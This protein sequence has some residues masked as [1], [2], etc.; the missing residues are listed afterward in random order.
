[1]Y[2]LNINNI[3]IIQIS[4]FIIDWSKNEQDKKYKLSNLRLQKLLYF[5]QGYHFLHY[6]SELFFEDLEAWKYGPVSPDVYY[7]L[8][9]FGKNE[10][11]NTIDDN[12]NNQLPEYIKELLTNLLKATSDV[13]TAD[14]IQRTHN[15]LPWVETYY[16]N[17]AFIIPKWLIRDYYITKYGSR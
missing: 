14:L 7:Q 3:S 2:D 16:S 8:K 4:N 15:E 13:S 6:K 10:V 5:A 12:C 1:M 11:N 9:K 17:G